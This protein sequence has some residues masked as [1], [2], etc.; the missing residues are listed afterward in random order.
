MFI[1][2]FA[3]GFA[4]KRVTPQV[5]FLANLAGTPPGGPVLAV[6]AVVGALVFVP[7]TWWV[8]R[9]RGPRAAAD[10]D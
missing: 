10:S 6:A 3:L 1:G 5:S 4:A 2:H 9:H 8:D 7:W